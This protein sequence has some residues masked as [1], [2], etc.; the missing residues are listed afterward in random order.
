MVNHDKMLKLGGFSKVVNGGTTEHEG[1]AKKQLPP[2]TPHREDKERWR[3]NQLGQAVPDEGVPQEKLRQMYV[4]A[5]L[6]E[7][8]EEE[9]ADH[10][11]SLGTMAEQGDQEC[12]KVLLSWLETTK[13]AL[14]RKQILR[15]LV[16]AGKTPHIA[17]CREII[18][19]IKV[20][21]TDDEASIRGM[22]VET[23]DFAVGKSDTAEIDNVVPVDKRPEVSKLRGTA[24]HKMREVA[25][26]LSERVLMS[27][28]LTLFTHAVLPVRMATWCLFTE[29]LDVVQLS[30][31]KEFERR[32]HRRRLAMAQAQKEMQAAADE[33][34]QTVRAIFDERRAEVANTLREEAHER[35]VDPNQVLSGH[36]WY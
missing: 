26:A 7:E 2:D 6:Q 21:I 34:E 8:D 24:W 20:C 11:R 22:M 9:R 13:S 18:E 28:L 32:M 30:R 36:A 10:V 16:W 23:L 25:L 15:K 14:I 33:T 5:F 29:K 19:G 4:D 35:G 1:F 3:I 27:G 31:C 17:R 12:A